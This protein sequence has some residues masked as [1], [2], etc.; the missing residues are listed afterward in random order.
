MRKK[1]S[2]KTDDSNSDFHLYRKRPLQTQGTADISILKAP[3]A[4][5]LQG[6]LHYIKKDKAC[7]F[8]GHTRS[9][10]KG[11]KEKK[12][13]NIN[14]SI[15][16]S[17]RA[18]ILQGSLHYTKK[19]K[20]CKRIKPV[21]QKG[22]IWLYFKEAT[23][24]TVTADISIPRSPLP[25]ILHI[26]LHYTYKETPSN[27]LEKIGCISKKHPN[28]SDSRYLWNEGTNSNDIAGYY[29]SLHIEEHAAQVLNR[30]IKR[31]RKNRINMDGKD[32]GQNVDKKWAS[33]PPPKNPPKASTVVALGGSVANGHPLHCDQTKVADYI[34]LVIGQWNKSYTAMDAMKA[35][36][37]PEEECKNKS[38]QKRVR[39]QKI[40]QMKDSPPLFIE[41]V[42]NGTLSISS[43]T[44]PGNGEPPGAAA[45]AMGSAIVASSSSNPHKRKPTANATASAATASATTASAATATNDATLLAVTAGVAT[46]SVATARAATAAAPLKKKTRRNH[47]QLLLYDQA[48]MHNSNGRQQQS[49]ETAFVMS[50]DKKEQVEQHGGKIGGQSICDAVNRM[51]NTNISL[52]TLKWR[53]NNGVKTPLRHGRPPTLTPAIEEA[54]AT[55]METY[56]LLTSAE[57]LE[58]PNCKDMLWRLKECVKNGPCFLKNFES[59][60][61]RMQS[62]YAHTIEVSQL[63]RILNVD[64]TGLT[65]DGTGSKSGGRPVT[66]YAPA[67]KSLPCGATRTH[68][69]SSRCTLVAG[70]TAS[71]DPI[72]FHFQLKSLAQEGKRKISTAFTNPLD[73]AGC[74]TGTWGFAAEC[75]MPHTANC[76]PTAGM[77]GIEFRKYVETSIIALSPDAQP[78]NR[79]WVL[80][81]VTDQNFG[82]FK[83]AYRDNCKKLHASCSA[84]GKTVKMADLPSLVFGYRENWT[85]KLRSAYE[86]AFSPAASKACWRKIGVSPFTRNCLG[87][88][89]VVHQ[90]MMLPD[91]SIDL[92]ADPVTMQLLDLEFRNDNAIATLKEHGFA[93]EV[94]L[95]LAPRNYRKNSAKATLPNT[96]AR[97]DQIQE[98]KNTP[99]PKYTIL[100]ERAYNCTDQ[101]IVNERI[102]RGGIIKAMEG[103]KSKATA[104]GKKKEAAQPLIDKC[105]GDFMDLPDDMVGALMEAE[106]DPPVG[107]VKW[108]AVDEAEM[109]RLIEEDIKIKDTELGKAMAK[110]IKEMLSMTKSITPKEMEIAEAHLTPEELEH[111]RAVRM[112]WPCQG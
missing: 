23:Q 101:I 43:L 81:I 86:E 82:I 14:I 13:V 92:D 66:E 76:N 69:S 5:I 94:F 16:K 56:I 58:K 40:K 33:K 70:S 96:R 10:L 103:T 11:K 100:N 61:Y 38:M 45:V 104:Y 41:T 105:D 21:K 102:R 3:T 18:T 74:V 78:A 62:K 73:R 109:K 36:D 52:D 54:L 25:T 8:G 2:S 30:L 29:S 89:N 88:Q 19:D 15:L 93:G 111:L 47:S 91:G 32:D 72:P 107:E 84:E 20:A 77:D 17:P 68:K 48:T 60:F 55:A 112:N 4:T 110:D 53:V 26:P 49:Y 75:Q 31:I 1:R 98:A 67:N 57:M 35:L 71:G 9:I 106:E 59:L 108:S 51:T 39:R 34:L 7:N 83:N 22:E 44:H 24:I 65:L 37:F 80:L 87:D 90:L 85:L 46:A 97:Q 63:H 28:N 42:V 79:K 12:T 50:T 27:R 6:S 99:G 64:E 95:K